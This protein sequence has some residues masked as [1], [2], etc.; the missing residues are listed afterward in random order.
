MAFVIADNSLLQVLTTVRRLDLLSKHRPIHISRAVQ[1]EHKRRAPDPAEEYLQAQIKEGFV[2]VSSPG[3][4]GAATRLQNRYRALSPED[5]EGLAWAMKTNGFLLSEDRALLEAADAEGVDGVD[6]LALLLACKSGGLL[7]QTNLRTL[8]A[9]IEL[10][11][12]HN[13][14]AAAKRALGL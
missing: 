3:V 11:A 14:S 4:T 2:L 13:L 10:D 8:V 1:R 12:D 5:A 6:L 9:A 7:T